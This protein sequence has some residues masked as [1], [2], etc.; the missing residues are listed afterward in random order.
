MFCSDDVHPHLLE[1]IKTRCKIL[2]VNLVVDKLENININDDLFGV[3]FSYPNTYGQINFHQELIN[4]LNDNQTTVISQNDLM[5]LLL[6]KPPGELGVDIS[7]GSTQRFGLPLWYGGPHSAFFAMNERFLRKMPGRIIGESIDNS[8][9]L[10][11]RMT[12]QTREQHIKKERATSNI[13]TSQA[14][15]SIH[16][17]CMLFIMVKKD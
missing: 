5:S 2:D 9:N 13:C 15:L 14:L 1:I 16:L 8:G 12:L 4:K 7:L 3:Y 10:A 11:Y 6:L 17:V